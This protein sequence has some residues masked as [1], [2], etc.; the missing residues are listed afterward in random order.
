MRGEKFLKILLVL[1]C[2]P[3]FAQYT[4][5]DLG[6]TVTDSSGAAVPEAKVTVRNTD[7]GF[8]Q[9][10]T[11]S[12]TGAFL[13]PRLRVGAYELRVAKDGFTSYVQSGI[14]LAVDQAANISVAL[15]VGQVSNEVTVEGGAELVTT[16][17]A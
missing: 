1:C 14:A 6:G 16:R 12:S 5:A 10:T 9:D 3:L 11:S 2:V 15:Q 17:T 4:T 8:T 7:T 13:F